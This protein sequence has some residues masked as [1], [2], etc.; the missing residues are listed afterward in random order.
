MLRRPA[1]QLDMY[2]LGTQQ[3]VMKLNLYGT[4]VMQG[5]KGLMQKKFSLLLVVLCFY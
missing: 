3:A 1:S 2:C 5:F 4:H